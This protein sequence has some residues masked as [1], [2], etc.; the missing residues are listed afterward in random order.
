MKWDWRNSKTLVRLSGPGLFN[1]RLFGWSY[2]LLFIP[3][4]LFDV[5]AYE[6]TTWLWLT[7]WTFGHAAAGFVAFLIRGLGLDSYLEENPS[8]LLNVGV[9]ALL[10]IIRVTFI[11]YTSFRFG[12]VPQFDL[13]ARIIAGA[14]LGVLLFFLMVSILNSNRDYQKA[15]ANLLAAQAQLSNLRKAKQKEISAIEKE[16]AANTRAVVEPRLQEIAKALNA[17]Q[18]SGV[19]RRAITNQLKDLLENQIR[20]LTLK[21][22]ST[23]KTLQDP[24]K[25]RSVSRLNLLKVPDRM[26]PDLAL[27]P[28][29]VFLMLGALIPFSLY[30]FEGQQW[31]PT[32]FLIS[33]VNM[34]CFW[35]LKKFLQPFPS[36]PTFYGIVALFVFVASQA[37]L[38]Y[39]LL[40]I[41]D[42]PAR[43]D[44]FVTMLIFIA[45]LL[46]TTGYGLVA[47][48]EY[49]QENFLKKL[50]A[51]NRR[52]ER[53]LALLNQRLW[54]EKR[55]WALRVHGSV[56]ASLTAAITRLSSK[57]ELDKSDLTL[58]RQHISQARSGLTSAPVKTVSLTDSLKNLKATWRGIVK[59]TIDT[60][61]EPAQLVIAD[62]WAGACANEI[63]KEAVSNSVKH[64][65][66]DTVKIWFEKAAAGFVEIVIE[67]TGKGLPNQFR[68][69]LGSQL[70]DEIAFPWSLTK[71]PEG[72]S[73]LRARI[74]VAKGK[75]AK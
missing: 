70:L 44:F 53:E 14:I 41:V 38:D 30:V 72:G 51:N 11:G 50:T 64:G 23:S 27:K 74:P 28:L 63:I 21:L 29:Q 31:I 39:F 5:I 8:I 37:V 32:G 9:A 25:F 48:Y 33:A 7:I 26:N 54:V 59:I 12:L 42:F 62:K 36:I 15:L 16:L 35:V 61:S 49:N 57:S 73:I 67:D 3:Q 24:K 69:G 52:L 66:A 19:S 2:L 56:Q 71:R 58:I 46:T 18:M 43:D 47:T 40:R 45:L 4:I 34:I 68:P 65:K 22:R 1:L 13:G 60:K 20:P 55:Q 75:V 10:G 17:E 6:S